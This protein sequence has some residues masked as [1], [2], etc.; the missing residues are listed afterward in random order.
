[1]REWKNRHGAAGVGNAGVEIGLS[2]R[3][4]RHDSAGVEPCKIQELQL[5]NQ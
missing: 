5:Q 1:M 4:V 3:C 2:A